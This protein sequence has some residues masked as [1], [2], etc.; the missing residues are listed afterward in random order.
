MEETSRKNRDNNYISLIEASKLCSYS[1]PY[2]RL[3]ARQGK[4]KS[5]KLGKKWMTTAAWLDDYA[6]RVQEWREL[7]EAK[8]SDQPAATLVCAPVE[9]SGNL[10]QEIVPATVFESEP[11]TVAG[12]KVVFAD[13][14]EVDV[15]VA[16]FCADQK[17]FAMPRPKRLAA[18]PPAGQ[19]FP[20]PKQTDADNASGFGWF[21]ALLS[22]AVCALALFAAVSWGD[23]ANILNSGSE[24]IGQ[25][26]AR[27][28][29]LSMEL[30]R[31]PGEVFPS[32]NNFQ[33]F[34]FQ[35]PQDISLEDLVEYIVRFFDGR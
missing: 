26:N 16:V 8:R 13:N 24:R 1:E 30:G 23:I 4:L 18:Y 33:D 32:E 20:V 29:V 28:A 5:I 17:P 31:M 6:A 19:L 34:N 21:G 35:I 9:L 12:P 25:A 15:P 2:L 7:S 3:R 10:E 27:Q 22:G 14:A 11:A